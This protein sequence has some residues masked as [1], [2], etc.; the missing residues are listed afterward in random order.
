MPANRTQDT[1]DVWLGLVLVIPFAAHYLP[2]FVSD[3]L[4]GASLVLTIALTFHVSR[5]LAARRRNLVA[6]AACG[7][8]ISQ[9]DDLRLHCGAPTENA[10]G[11][12]TDAACHW[13]LRSIARAVSPGQ[14]RCTRTKENHHPMRVAIAT[15]NGAKFL[16]Q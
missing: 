6:G 3:L 14:I 1:L 15:F 16:S 7:Y 12:G 10:R 9:R 2:A 5:I 8:R 4:I 13:K 11:H